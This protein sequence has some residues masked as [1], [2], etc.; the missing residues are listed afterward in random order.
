MIRTLLV[1]PILLVFAASPGL[2]QQRASFQDAVKSIAGTI[3]PAEARPGQT[4]TYKLTVKL[5]HPYYTHPVKQPD[6]SVGVANS[7]N[8]IELPTTGELIFVEPISDPP[9]AKTKTSTLGTLAYYPEGAT[10]EFK[11]VVSPKSTPGDKRIA[12]KKFRPLVCNGETEFCFPPRPVPVEATVKVVGDP[13]EVEE[14]YRETVEKAMA[15]R[16]SPPDPK[17]PTPKVPSPTPKETP[18]PKTPPA[19]AAAATQKTIKLVPSPDY[20]QSLMTVLDNP[21]P[22]EATTGGV[23][24]AGFG[25]FLLTAALWGIITLLTPCVFPMVPI[26]VS[27]FLKQS[28]KQGTNAVKQAAV[29]ALTIVVVLGV[30]AMTLLEAFRAYRLIRG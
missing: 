8:E 17:T 12:L 4:V 2:A 25:T 15:T 3:E 30:S 19:I 6:M 29:Y 24:N 23:G 11:A 1:L 26:T 9:N 18:D 28:E 21:V 16:A 7:R 20:E 27:V 13:V 10:W 5:N 14:K 22:I